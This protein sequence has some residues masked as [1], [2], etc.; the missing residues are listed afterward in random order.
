MAK[1]RLSET[2]RDMLERLKKAKYDFISLYGS[3]SFQT[4]RSL[5]YRGLA[6]FVYGVG[7]WGRYIGI[8][9]KGKEALK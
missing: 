9:D 5:V 7:Q 6:E 8:T 2:Q 1:E 4:G 3:A